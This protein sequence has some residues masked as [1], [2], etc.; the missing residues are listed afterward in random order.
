SLHVPILSYIYTPPLH[1]ALPIFNI[2]GPQKSLLSLLYK[3][4]FNLYD[5]NLAILNG[6]G[7]LNKYLPKQ[8]KVISLNPLVTYSTLPP[9]NFLTNSIKCLF[10]TNYIFSI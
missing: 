8:V 4:D 2:G 6:N 3:L 7:S 9:K 1:D 5:V 10:S